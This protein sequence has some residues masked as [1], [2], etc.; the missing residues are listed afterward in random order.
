MWGG[1]LVV[2]AT[3]TGTVWDPGPSPPWLRQ[4]GCGAGRGGPDLGGRKGVLVV[5]ATPP[6][7]TTAAAAAAATLII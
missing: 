7:T 1:L 6:T 5:E 2:E 4:G 3:R